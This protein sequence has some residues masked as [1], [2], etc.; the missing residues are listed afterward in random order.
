MG[1]LTNGTCACPP[2]YEGINCTEP[3]CNSPACAA[4]T[5]LCTA[6]N[7]CTCDTGFAGPACDTPL[8]TDEC[9]R[10]GVC[11]SP[12]ECVC[13][14]GFTGDSCA[15]KGAGGGG[16]GGGGGASGALVLALG[17][18]VALFVCL[19]LLV[20]RAKMTKPIIIMQDAPEGAELGPLVTRTIVTKRRAWGIVQ[21]TEKTQDYYINASLD[22]NSRR[23]GLLPSYD[24]SVSRTASA[25]TISLA[26]R[27]HAHNRVGA[28]PATSGAGRES[29][30][31]SLHALPLSDRLHPPGLIVHPPSTAPV[32]PIHRA[33]GSA[34]DDGDAPEALSGA[35]NDSSRRSRSRSSRRLRQQQLAASRSTG[36]IAAIQEA[37][38]THS[39]AGSGGFSDHT[40]G[41]SSAGASDR[42]GQDGNLDA[43]RYTPPP[44]YNELEAELQQAARRTRLIS[45]RAGR[46]ARQNSS[47]WESRQAHRQSV[48]SGTRPLSRGSSLSSSFSGQAHWSVLA[49]EEDDDDPLSASLTGWQQHP[50]VRI[51][52]GEEGTVP[53]SPPGARTPI[54]AWA[55]GGEASL[56]VSRAA[57]AEEAAHDLSLPGQTTAAGCR[58]VPPTAL[59]RGGGGS[60]LASAPASPRRSNG[61]GGLPRSMVSSL[62]A[63]GG[64]QQ[65]HMIHLPFLR[66]P[67]PVRPWRMPADG[68]AQLIAEP[69]PVNAESVVRV[70]RRG[71]PRPDSPLSLGTV[72]TDDEAGSMVVAVGGQPE[73][74][75]SGPVVV[76]SSMS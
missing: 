42:G 11:T 38:G 32:T 76:E 55:D 25:T 57:G 46:R 10:N 9:N 29:I 61:P 20:V 65:A 68:S 71:Q 33:A 58:P 47:A 52:V 21:V 19:L 48:G 2:G 30:G 34:T 4:E 23:A 64:A 37:A 3:V 63:S 53:G 51:T 69:N 26:L 22:A 73:S 15:E 31:R 17:G 16:G 59:P 5:G 27:R 12:D 45:R 54:A 50:S 66:T 35:A 41:S 14:D 44:S 43:P 28:A 74:S 8:C 1:C 39:A 18:V 13:L 72:T 24:Q 67:L 49:D 60:S 6:P 70:L 40:A 62:S 7:L 75:L 36:D 56:N